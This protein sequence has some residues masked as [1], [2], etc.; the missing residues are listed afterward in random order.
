MREFG[1]W[2]FQVVLVVIGL[3]ERGLAVGDVSHALVGE[4][5]LAFVERAL[6]SSERLRISDACER[7][8]LLK[9]HRIVTRQV[10]AGTW[11][12]ATDAVEVRVRIRLEVEAAEVVGIPERQVRREGVVGP[13]VG[14]VAHGAGA[15]VLGDVAELGDRA[16]N[17]GGEGGFAGEEIAWTGPFDDA[18]EVA[19]AR[20]GERGADGEVWIRVLLREGD[21]TELRERQ[22]RSAGNR[23]E[24]DVALADRVVVDARAPEGALLVSSRGEFRVDERTV[25]NALRLHPA[26][27]S[28]GF[29]VIPEQLRL[30]GAVAEEE[31]RHRGIAHLDGCLHAI[32]TRTRA[33]G[34]HA[35]A[36]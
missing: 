3:G 22:Q 4:Q 24:D 36:S 16:F 33:A 27:R 15:H 10:G 23:V 8:H 12:V 28:V 32:V 25:Q 31:R 17:V 11:P 26:N 35:E 2:K 5:A 30:L 1:F 9:S 18:G 21:G 7:G 14:A 29:T 6:V 19:D 34:L 20:V 13:D